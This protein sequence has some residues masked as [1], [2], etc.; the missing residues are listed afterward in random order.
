[1]DHH[2]W[3]SFSVLFHFSEFPPIEILRHKLS[4]RSVAHDCDFTTDDK[5]SLSHIYIDCDK[6]SRIKSIDLSVH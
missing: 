5:I 1:M 6:M 2:L 3:S 4:F